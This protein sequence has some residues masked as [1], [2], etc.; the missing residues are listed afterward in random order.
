MHKNISI[1]IAED[2]ENLRALYVEYLELFF[3]N[4]Y[5]ARD[6]LQA[7]EIYQ[8]KAPDIIVSDIGMPKLD[9]IALIQRIRKNDLKTQILILSAY[10]DQELLLEAVKLHLFEYLVKPVP[11]EKL[12]EILLKMISSIEVQ[13]DYI[14]LKN[15]YRWLK[16]TQ[17]FYFEQE[18]IEFKESEKRVLE[19]LTKSLNSSVSNESMY[20]YIYA[21]IPE[22]EFSIHAIQAIIKR[23]RKKLPPGIIMTNYSS[24][25]SLNIH[26]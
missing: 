20:Q 2:D 13:S 25:Y 9:G 26:I 21:D 10:T 16:N 1:L 23:I 17:D 11:S 18:L 24:G 15:G 19:L 8:S 6:G 22:K 14:D 12:K 3:A 5:E 7:Y 4:V